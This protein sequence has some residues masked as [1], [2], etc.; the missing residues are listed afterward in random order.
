MKDLEQ[1]KRYLHSQNNMGGVG[2]IIP[3]PHPMHIRNDTLDELLVDLDQNP[4]INVVPDMVGF[5]LVESKRF[6]MNLVG[7]NSNFP[8]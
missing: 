6:K 2:D 4:S 3:P 5:Q 8:K 7:R 1:A